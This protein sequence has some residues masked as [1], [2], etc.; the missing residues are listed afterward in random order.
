M[1]GIDK[2]AN[3]HRM[4]RS[5]LKF[6]LLDPKINEMEVIIAFSALI[7]ASSHLDTIR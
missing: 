4:V 6:R 2:T 7:F 3:F 5:N 1:E